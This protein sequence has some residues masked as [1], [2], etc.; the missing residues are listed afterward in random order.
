MNIR[1]A[2]E[3]YHA[4]YDPITLRAKRKIW[5]DC[6]DYL[7]LITRDLEYR[8][9]KYLNVARFEDTPTVVDWLEENYEFEEMARDSMIPILK[10]RNT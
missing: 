3:K 5:P 2:L 10:L 8:G 4:Y 9:S 7:Y 6:G 1:E